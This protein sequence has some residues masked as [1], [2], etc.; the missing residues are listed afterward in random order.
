[1]TQS[2]GLAQSRVYRLV[3]GF[4]KEVNRSLMQNEQ[5]VAS[6][7]LCRMT[8]AVVKKQATY[9][10]SK[11]M[12]TPLDIY[13]MNSN[14]LNVAMHIINIKMNRARKSLVSTKK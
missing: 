10:Q 11:V 12:L 3:C 1:M 4:N 8:R 6:I 13:G 14:S 2:A 7:F 5:S 9:F